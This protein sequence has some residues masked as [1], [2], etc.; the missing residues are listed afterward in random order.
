[1]ILVSV[2]FVLPLHGRRIASADNT[3]FMIGKNTFKIGFDTKYLDY[4]E[5]NYMEE[6]VWVYGIVGK[7]I[8]HGNNELMFK[9]S[10]DIV[11]GE[12]DYDRQTQF[13]TPVKAGMDD[14]LFEWKGL[15]GKSYSFKGNSIVT[16]FTGI[17]YRLWNNNIN[18][19]GG[20]ERE[21]QFWYLPIGVETISSLIGNWTLGMNMEY[22]LFL[23]GKGKSH[24]SDI[25]PAYNF[26]NNRDVGDGYGFRLSLQFNRKLSDNYGFSVEPYITYWE[27]NESDTSTLTGYGIP[28]DYLI[29]PVNEITVYGLRLIITY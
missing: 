2:I 29:E 7:Y 24:F 12:T 22:D 16:P 26:E 5:E 6:D 13:G 10:L 21:M 19:L 11:F 28:I 20:Y 17:G 1:M 8:Y 25:D 23:R 27:I 18:S 14:S 3:N 4:E 9:T 15:I